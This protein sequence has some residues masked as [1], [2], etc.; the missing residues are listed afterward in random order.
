MDDDVK[1]DGFYLLRD[2][3][4]MMSRDVHCTFAAV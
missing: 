1:I 4:L 2:R 3:I